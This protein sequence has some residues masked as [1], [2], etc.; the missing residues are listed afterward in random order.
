MKIKH[1]QNV[2]ITVIVT[3]NFKTIITMITTTIKFKI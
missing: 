1:K 3:L 2:L